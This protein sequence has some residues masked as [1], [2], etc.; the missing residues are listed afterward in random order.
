MIN[1]LINFLNFLYIN[2]IGYNPSIAPTKSPTKLP[3]NQPTKTPSFLPTYSPI[4]SSP[5]I[6]C[7][8]ATTKR[9]CNKLK[10]NGCIYTNNICRNSICIDNNNKK[11]CNK[12]SHNDCIY[13][14]F[15]KICTEKLPCI[16]YDT[17]ENLC[18]SD[19]QCTFNT[20]C[21]LSI[22]SDNTNKKSCNNDKYNSCLY[23]KKNNKACIDNLD[24][25]NYF[26]ENECIA[27]NCIWNDTTCSKPIC[28]TITKNKKCKKYKQYCKFKNKK[29]LDK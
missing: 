28:S 13:D 14:S 22:C 23:V 3:S 25:C 12:D 17:N 4:T 20:T 18:I 29:C 24:N 1:N 19:N 10:S 27:D 21:R 5:T 15:N 16:D 9:K 2:I 11:K 26:D 6:I 8:I 7:D